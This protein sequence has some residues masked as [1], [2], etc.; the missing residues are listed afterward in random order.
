MQSV[1]LEQV[2]FVPGGGVVVVGS[3]VAAPLVSLQT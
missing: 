2:D 3:Q 1:S